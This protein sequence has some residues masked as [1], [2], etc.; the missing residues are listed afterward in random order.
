MDKKQYLLCSAIWYQ[1]L[2]TAKN[3]PKNCDR[4]VVV[5]GWRHGNIIAT[6]LSLTGL[7]TVQF[8]P[9]SVG[10]SVQ[11]FL[12]NDNLF[13]DREEAGLLHTNQAK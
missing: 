5:C 4:G 12:T 7:R 9:N 1:D 11:G 6:V 10:E 8:G 2:P 3:L 13:V